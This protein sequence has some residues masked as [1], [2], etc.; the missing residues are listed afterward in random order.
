MKCQSNGS[1]DRFGESAKQML[2]FEV[3]TNENWFLFRAHVAPRIC[4]TLWHC[5]CFSRMEMTMTI[6]TVS[7]ENGYW[8][9]RMEK[10]V[11]EQC[12]SNLNILVTSK[13]HVSCGFEIIRLLPSCGCL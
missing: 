13:A 8:T 2:M 7:S 4:G 3:I 10:R 9:Y 12:I 1:N 6:E 5:G 11:N